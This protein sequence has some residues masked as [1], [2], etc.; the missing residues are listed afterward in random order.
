MASSNIPASVSAFSILLLPAEV[1]PTRAATFTPD[2]LR[3]ERI[4]SLCFSTSLRSRLSL[5]ILSL[6]SRRS[7]SSFFSP[8]PLVPI[9]PPSLESDLP[10]P[11]RREAR[12]RSW[13]SSTCILP[14]PDT[15]RAAKISRIRS[16]RSMIL[17]ESSASRLPSWALVSSSSHMIPVASVSQI[18]SFN[19]SNLP[20]P[21]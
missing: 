14:S 10:N 9:P 12:Y 2:C 7:I 8:G 13:A 16:V 1:Y 21:I 11:V 17:Q 20:F 18:R 3:C 15:A 5:L 4:N 6:I 19:S